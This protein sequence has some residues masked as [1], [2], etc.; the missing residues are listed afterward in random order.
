MDM[1]ILTDVGQRRTNNQDYANQYT[2]KAGKPMVFL[3]DGMGGHR[4]GNIASEMAVTDLGAAW[5]SSEIET[6]N[7]VREW[8]AE[9]L[10]AVNRRIHLAGQDDEH[11]G[12]G[13]TLEALAF[14][15]GQVIYAHVGDSRI[16]LIRQG[17][18][19]HHS[20]VNA[21]L[22]A[23]QITE[24]E[25]AHHPQRNIITQSIGQKDELEPDYGLVTVEADD[26]ILINSD[27]LTN[28]IGPDEIRDIVLSD[29]SLE[30]K[31]QTL[32]R[33]ANNAGGL[34]NITVVLLHFTEEDAA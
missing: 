20:L 12:M 4:A 26:Y 17:E 18:Y 21:L 23:G 29:V 10:E 33:F 3:A 24:E 11:K 6:V 9:H 5:V 14:V 22:R 2:N 1:T 30:E 27:G 15:E 19:Q 28:M 16:G 8:F 34:D 25:A 31:A 32:I 13:T 7:Q